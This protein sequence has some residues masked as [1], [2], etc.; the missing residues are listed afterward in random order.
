MAEKGKFNVFASEKE[1]ML[2]GKMSRKNTWIIAASV[3]VLLGLGTYLFIR[4]TANRGFQETG[5]T[6]QL[7]SEKTPT[8]QT[9]VGT[10][11]LQSAPFP[12]DANYQSENFRVGDI[13][14]GGE[15]EFLLTEDTPEPIAISSISGEAFSEKN[16]Q[17]VKLS[18]SWET[19]KL[20]KSTITYSKGAGQATKTVTEEE[21]S[22]NHS[23]II[24]GLEQ[25]STY[26]YTIVSQDRFGNAATSEP[27]A[28][29][30]GAGTASLFDLI[31]NAIGDIFGWAIN[32]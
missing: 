22:L 31:A 6:V 11:P 12:G 20:A 3:F 23:L 2:F 21:Y 14:I 13:A 9:A 7:Q 28:V 30:T 4:W 19:N 1:R 15:A 10:T 16:K 26:I 8:P 25:S 17:E 32:K 27:H 5:L 24:S 29:Y 18:L